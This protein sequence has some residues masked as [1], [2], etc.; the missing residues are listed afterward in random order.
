M[1]KEGYRDYG[2]DMGNSH[3]RLYDVTSWSY[4]NLDD[5]VGEFL[6]DAPFSNLVSAPKF[7]K[8]TAHA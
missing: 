8:R 3:M 2:V 7:M 5:P 6:S 4:V 1:Y